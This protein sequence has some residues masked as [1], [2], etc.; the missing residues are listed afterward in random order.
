[1]VPSPATCSRTGAAGRWLERRLE[2]GT[3]APGGKRSCQDPAA[4]GSGGP[5]ILGPSRADAKGPRPVPAK[6]LNL[7]HSSN[8]LSLPLLETPQGFVVGPQS[9]EKPGGAEVLLNGSL[10]VS[11]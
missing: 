4:P 9:S 7:E 1:M 8:A 6:G 11:T 10:R 3:G 5:G 2:R